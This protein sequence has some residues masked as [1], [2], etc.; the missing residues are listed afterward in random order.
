MPPY[1]IARSFIF[2]LASP[3]P[4]PRVRTFLGSHLAPR[5][6]RWR[7]TSTR[8]F[9]SR[10]RAESSRKRIIPGRSCR[11]RTAFSSERSRDALDARQDC[12][13]S[14]RNGPRRQKRSVCPRE[15]A[16]CTRA[17]G[18]AQLNRRDFTEHIPAPTP[19]RSVN[20]HSHAKIK[21]RPRCP[22]GDNRRYADWSALDQL[23]RRVFLFEDLWR[24][25]PSRSRRSNSGRLLRFSM[26][27]RDRS[28]RAST[29]NSNDTSSPKRDFSSRL[30]LSLV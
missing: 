22:R 17:S 18:N 15:H 14:F 13:V 11:S 27:T 10:G 2:A 4:R 21:R 19:H 28:V 9:S 26:V 23:S 30:A 12:G 16:G 8:S 20:T 25:I 5:D 3:L 6:R 1:F 24:F 7:P 29:I